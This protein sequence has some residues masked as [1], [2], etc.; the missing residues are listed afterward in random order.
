[1]KIYVDSSASKQL[2]A[3][4]EEGKQAFLARCE[5][6]VSK[7]RDELQFF[8]GWSSL[9]EYLNLGSLFVDLPPLDECNKIFHTVIE[10]LKLDAEKEVVIYLYD[11]IFVE[12][13]TQIKGLSQVRPPCLLDRIR[14][15]IKKSSVNQAQ[16]P[17]LYALQHYET[18]FM[19]NA[20]N[21]LHDL[22]LYLAW[23]RV[24]VYL[25][26]VF[27]HPYLKL[28][29]GLEVLKAC[30]VESFEHITKQGRT[31]PSFSR[32][33]EAL[34]V[35]EMK[36][37]NIQKHTDSQWQI[38]CESLQVLQSREVLGG[39]CYIDMGI[40]DLISRDDSV[41]VLTMDSPKQVNARLALSN[42]MLATLTAEYTSWRYVFAPCEVLYL[43]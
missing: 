29:H 33:V 28:Q 12:C 17:F 32:L 26:A 16:D 3:L 22:I 2:T 27:D 30:L 20:E 38:L 5:A 15:K 24:C 21:T 35:Y 23:D 18:M 39:S 37:E 7:P 1:M 41:K 25:T 10:V 36:D 34:Y 9:L 19:E 6:I 40:N 31:I 11:Q 8:L 14:E 4:T 13:L 43:Y 42:I